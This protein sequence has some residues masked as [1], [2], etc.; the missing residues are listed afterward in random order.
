MIR[1]LTVIKK[2]NSNTLKEKWE[3]QIE[4]AGQKSPDSLTVR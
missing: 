3:I 4:I 1:I 2:L